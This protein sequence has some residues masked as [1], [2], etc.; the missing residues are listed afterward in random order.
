MRASLLAAA[1]GLAVLAL[2][3]DA[4]AVV[5][6]SRSAERAP[7]RVLAD[8]RAQEALPAPAAV[9]APAAAA[10]APSFERQSERLRHEIFAQLNSVSARFEDLDA[11]IYEIVGRLQ[12]LAVCLIAFF[13]G[14]LVWQMS[15]TRQMARIEAERRASES[16]GLG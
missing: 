16:G 5:R 15:L 13:I 14:V 11:R 8:I 2:V 9:A 10:A 3:H 4:R 6:A 1:V 7:V 12:L